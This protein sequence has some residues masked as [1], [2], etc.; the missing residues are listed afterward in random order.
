M[1]NRRNKERLGSWNQSRSHGGTHPMWTDPNAC[2]DTGPEPQVLSLA[3]L[4]LKPLKTDVAAPTASLDSPPFSFLVSGPGG[5][6]GCQT[7]MCPCLC[8]K[9]CWESDPRLG[10]R[11]EKKLYFPPVLTQQGASHEEQGVQVPGSPERYKSP[12][13]CPKHTQTPGCRGLLCF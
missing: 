13:P 4:P 3:S 5:I 12:P 7:Q 10:F 1:E 9:G 6:L 8:C 2:D 11:S